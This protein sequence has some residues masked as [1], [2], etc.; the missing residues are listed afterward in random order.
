MGPNQTYLPARWTICH[1]PLLDEDTEDSDFPSDESDS[2]RSSS[3]SEL[4][5]SGDKIL[6]QV[7][8]GKKKMVAPKAEARDAMQACANIEASEA[9]ERQ[10]HAAKE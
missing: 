9:K 6:A 10:A 5:A 2:S 1:G 7:P 8:G 4:H 3:D